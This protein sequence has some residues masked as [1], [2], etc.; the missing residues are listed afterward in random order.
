MAISNF[1]PLPTFG[2]YSALSASDLNLLTMSQVFVHNSNMVVYP[3]WQ[4]HVEDYRAMYHKPGYN[5]ILWRTETIL[6]NDRL[7]INGVSYDGISG[8]SGYVWLDVDGAN[9][10]GLVDDEPYDIGWRSGGTDPIDGIYFIETPDQTG[11]PFA[12]PQSIKTFYTG[13]ALT[14]IDLNDIVENVNY[15]LDEHAYH[16]VPG[17][18]YLE[19]SLPQYA[20]T[21][22][23]R[24][25]YF[26]MQ[27]LSRY[28]HIVLRHNSSGY[29]G[30]LRDLNVRVNGSSVYGSTFPGDGG[31]HDYSIIVDTAGTDHEVVTG[32]SQTI[33]SPPTLTYGEYYKIDIM[34]TGP[35]WSGDSV[36]WFLIAEM[37]GHS[38]VPR[39]DSW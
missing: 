32:T 26:W 14:A 39:G 24:E 7:W 34:L 20:A 1:V 35:L 31:G 10:Y 23:R 30:E 15:V 3:Q 12:Y 8:T 33:T 2:P 36:E 16:V 21:E 29:N 19:E 13:E 37:P 9:P 5:H 11:T 28:L 4:I 25:R 22:V 38:P 27:H 18:R 6:N 17:F